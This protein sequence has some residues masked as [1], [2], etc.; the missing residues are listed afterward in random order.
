[1]H[2]DHDQETLY[3]RR[4]GHAVPFR[5]CRGEN[6]GSP[7]RL[8]LDCWWQQFDVEDYFRTHFPPEVLDTLRVPAPPP[9]KVA[10]IL[11]LIQKARERMDNDPSGERGAD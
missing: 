4:L 9:P 10:T 7:C 8:T 1:M 2:D 3:C 5:Y 6:G 11:D